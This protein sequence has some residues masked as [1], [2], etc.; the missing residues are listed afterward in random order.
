MRLWSALF[1]ATT[2]VC[3]AGA[4][5]VSGPSITAVTNSFSASASIAPNSFLSIYGSNL[6]PPGDARAWKQSDFVNGQLPTALDGVSVTLN[7][8]NA[9]VSYISATQLNVLTTPD[10]AAGPVTV[11]VKVNGQM[12]AAFTTQAQPLAAILLTFNGSPY[13]TATHAGGSLIGPQTLYPGAST[14]AQPGEEIVLYATGFGAPGVIKGS[15][16]QSGTLP[17]LP[18][19]QIGGLAA[20]VKFAGLILPGLFQFNVV[21]PPSIPDGDNTVS[22][23]YAGQSTQTG[24]LL[25]TDFVVI[26]L[27][28]LI[29]P[30]G[31]SATLSWSSANATSC[32]ASNAWSGS[33]LATGSQP[34]A[35]ATPGYYTYTLTCTGAGRMSSQSAVLTSYGPPQTINYGASQASYHQGYQASFYVAPPN[36]V[37]RLQTSLTVPPFPPISTTPGAALFLWPGIDP[38]TTSANFLPIDNGVLQPVLSWGPSCAPVVQPKPFSS[39]WISAQYVN[40]FGSAAG[41]TGCQSGPAMSVNPGDVLLIDMALDPSTGVWSQTVTD[42]N[43]GQTVS[44]SINLQGQGQNWVYFAIE[45]WYG[46]TIK[47]PVVFSNTTITFKTPDTARWCS[48]SQAANPNG[49]IMTPPTPENGAAQ[50]F[51][52]TVVLQE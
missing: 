38:A 20:T 21:V 33:Q 15:Q 42:A 48:T 1:L 6:A 51:I 7:G 23:Q 50:C 34:V 16:T 46:A 11:K 31:K 13:V 32:N 36:Q 41:F 4:Q 30:A 39:W 25:T 19:I 5:V 47:T 12:S 43:T 3:S 18:A 52:S 28:N 9:Y 45:Q 35:P 44:F 17:S 49:Y 29:V 2:L 14:P 37:V 40:T 24:L 8:D 26:S 22:V 27:S 10:L